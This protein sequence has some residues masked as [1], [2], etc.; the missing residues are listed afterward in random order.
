MLFEFNALYLGRKE[1]LATI[2]K[3]EGRG[4]ARQEEFEL[5]TENANV[6]FQKVFDAQLD[7]II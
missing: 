3:K 5:E 6:T 1:N 2:T 4:K 7:L